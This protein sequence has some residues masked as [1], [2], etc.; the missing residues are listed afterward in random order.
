MK[1][2]EEFEMEKHK[3]AS[4]GGSSMEEEATLA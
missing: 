2:G 4:G 3:K 1:V